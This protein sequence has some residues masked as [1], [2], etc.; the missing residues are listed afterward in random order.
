MTQ[1][2]PNR[3]MDP[4][5]RCQGTVEISQDHHGPYIHCLNCGHTIDLQLPEDPPGQPPGRP[6]VRPDRVGRHHGPRGQ[7]LRE[8]NRRW[9]EIIERE[10]LSVREAEARFG[11]GYRTLY[12]ALAEN[13]RRPTRPG[14]PGWTRRIST[15]TATYRSGEVAKFEDPAGR[16]G[17]LSNSAEG[18]PL[19]V[20]GI[21]FQGPESLYQALK[22][23]RL[24]DVQRHIASRQSADEAVRAAYEAFGFR[25]GSWRRVRVRAMMYTQA[26]RLRQHP[27]RFSR[28][29]MATGDLPIVE[30]SSRDPFWGAR[31]EPGDGSLLKGANVMGKVLAELR[32]ELR[33]QGGDAARVAAIFMEGADTG[34]LLIDGK[35]L[36]RPDQAAD[37]PDSM[38][39]T[40]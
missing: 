25:E 36:P 39:G 29:L 3:N 37:G 19:T 38:G 17:D 40:V 23:F 18:Y 20:N 34:G 4:C 24:P 30:V 5:P 31:P 15:R 35:P 2:R 8:R 7:D 11:I 32:D 12:R 28:A 6:G 16:H 26:V 27:A 13:R 9:A 14:D 21:E 22:F 1:E 10:G 33:R